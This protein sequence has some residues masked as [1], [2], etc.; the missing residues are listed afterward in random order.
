MP[1]R[2]RFTPSAVNWIVVYS[3]R[4]G[5]LPRYPGTTSEMNTPSQGRPEDR[6]RAN[7]DRLLVGAGW[8]IQNRDSVNIDA[9]RGIA[10]R[11][12]LLAPKYGFADYLLYVDGYAAGVVEAKKEGVPLTEVELQTDRYSAGLPPTLPAPPASLAILLPVHWYRNP[13]HQS[14]RT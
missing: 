6:A 8:S 5:P 13:L 12:F 1:P 2:Y 9:A 11:E 4:Y 10:I 7:I 14:L 3:T